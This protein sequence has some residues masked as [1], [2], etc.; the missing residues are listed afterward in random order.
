MA[1]LI[2]EFGHKLLQQ[3]LEAVPRY[4][5]MR[6]I[7]NMPVNDPDLLLA[8]MAA[9]ESRPVR[10]L[11]SQQKADGSW[12]RFYSR[13]K[14]MKNAGRTTES[15]I[16]R[17]LALG[18]DREH[19]A[20][21]H[22][23]QYLEA[24]LEH[25]TDWPDRTDDFQDFHRAH[26]MVTA[27]RLRSLDP[28][29]P[30]A[31]SVADQWGRMIR[32]SIADGVFAEDRIDEVSEA[33]FGE[34]LPRQCQLCFSAYQLLLLR[35]RLPY[36]TEKIWIDHLI[37]RSRGVAFL[38]NHSLRYFPLTFPS[39]EGLRYLSVLDHLGWYTTA[40]D[41]LEPAADWLWEQRGTDWWDFGP[42][43]R[44][45]LELP[46]AESWHSPATRSIDCSI[47]ALVILAR[48]QRTCRLDRVRGALI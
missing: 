13:N 37:N 38:N 12:G 35:G 26:L 7:L 29:N 20:I 46:L 18:L 14:I 39:Q 43:G 6:D 48:L 41:L 28:D 5:V 10:D 32:E 27:A 25:Q 36:P 40:T 17:A 15:A 16:I 34:S 33:I 24:I 30:L 47:R 1:D 44:D 22:T 4:R 3:S 31:L 21:Q 8:R 9:W 11:L 19:P 23:I 42:Q 45:G 2:Y